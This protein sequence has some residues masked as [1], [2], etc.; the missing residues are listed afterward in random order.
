MKEE[1]CTVEEFRHW[2]KVQLVYRDISLSELARQMGIPQPRISEAIHGKQSG[3]KHVIPI[4]E[5]LG[6]KREDF[7]EFLNAI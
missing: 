4:I 3:N 1:I 6:G 2:V 7:E 5:K